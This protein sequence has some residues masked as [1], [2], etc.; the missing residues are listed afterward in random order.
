[1]TTF[2]ET[3]EG[4]P[5][6]DEAGNAGTAVIDGGRSQVV[7]LDLDSGSYALVCFVTDREG[8]EPHVAQGMITEAEVE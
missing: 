5:P 6:F 2:L 7:D 4:E 3:E 1:V 8:G